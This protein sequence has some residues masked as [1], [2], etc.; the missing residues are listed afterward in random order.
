MSDSD[1]NTD[2]QALDGNDTPPLPER[3]QAHVPFACIANDY[4]GYQ[5]S[6]LNDQDLARYGRTRLVRPGP[7]MGPI[8]HILT[9]YVTNAD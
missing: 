3:D 9:E 6:A 8:S 1:E 2:R 5:T 4:I 7:Q